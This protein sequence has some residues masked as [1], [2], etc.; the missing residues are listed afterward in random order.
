MFTAFTDLSYETPFLLNWYMDLSFC[1]FLEWLWL[2][3]G[4]NVP[5]F[6]N[7]ELPKGVVSKT[8]RYGQPI[9]QDLTHKTFLQ[10]PISVE[11]IKNIHTVQHA[12]MKHLYHI[13]IFS[14]SIREILR[15]DPNNFSENFLIIIFV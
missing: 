13:Y 2:D 14:I 3:S 1:N 9:L 15:N 8:S 10:P 6:Y 11:Q 4:P 7:A 12:N 5:C